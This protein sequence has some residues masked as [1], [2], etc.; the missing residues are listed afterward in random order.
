MQKV[1][2]TVEG[3]WLCTELNW[4]H[5]WMQKELRLVHEDSHL[6][7]GHARLELLQS[8]CWRAELVNHQTILKLVDHEVE[9][10]LKMSAW[11]WGH[12]F[13]R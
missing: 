6:D 1:N 11:R 8:L 7:V 2:G 5:S 13:G 4:V 3:D 9:N 12:V 10:R